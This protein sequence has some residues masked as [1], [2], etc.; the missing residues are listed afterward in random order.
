MV[1]RRLVVW[2][3]CVYIIRVFSQTTGSAAP[4]FSGKTLDGKPVRLSDYRGRVILLDFWASWCKPCKE[5]FPFLI[6]TD[7]HFNSRG[8]TILTVNIDKNIKN[9]RQFISGLE[10]PPAFPVILDDKAGIPPLY[11]LEGMPTTILIDR[12]GL[13]RYIHVGFKSDKKAEY[14]EQI[15]TLLEENTEL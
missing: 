12:N 10:T 7:K 11:K 1:S 9:V 15:K 2:I 14:L 4:I 5:E 3:F 6:E 13:I 8:L